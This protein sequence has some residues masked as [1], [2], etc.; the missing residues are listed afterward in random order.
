M[1]PASTPRPKFRRRAEARPDEVLD[2]AL[3]LFTE[4]GYART[5]VEQI[6]RRAGLSK[7]AVYLY[8]PS[9]EA[10]LSGLVERSIGPIT[11]AAF[12]MID[13]WQ[14]DPRPAIGRFLRMIGAALGDETVRAVPM[15][16]L[17][18]APAAPDIAGLF[19]RAVL[20]RAI[21][22]VTGL[23]A[24]GVAAGHIRAVDPELTTRTIMGPVL[25]HVILAEIFAIEPEQGL[26]IDR[27]VENHL[28]ILFAGL[29][30]PAPEGDAA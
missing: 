19:R 3:A 10:L 17:R 30:P 16:V 4:Q 25:A 23:L 1:T 9:K 28:T 18:E 8:F 11:G 29:E 12:D 21:P 22:A 2:A 14:G 26:A 27:L 24:R 13:A 20:D 15:L 6:A 5:T 7:G